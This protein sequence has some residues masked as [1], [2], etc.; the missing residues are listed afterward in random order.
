MPLR[1][2]RCT[3]LLLLDC[4]LRS[5]PTPPRHVVDMNVSSDGKWVAVLL[6]DLSNKRELEIRD[7]NTGMVRWTA[8]GVLC[9]ALGASDQ[10]FL[11]SG[12]QFQ[13]RTLGT[14][15]P[16]SSQPFAVSL[17]PVCAIS[18][19][20][21]LI[22]TS[23]ADPGRPISIIDIADG[24]TI[25]T[26]E[27]FSPQV[28]SLTFSEDSQWLASGEFNRVARVWE[29]ASGIE[30]ENLSGHV[31]WV[32]ATRFSR[33]GR[34]LVTSSYGGFKLWD[35]PGER[36]LQD[37]PAV[38][39]KP[40]PLVFSYADGRVF[41]VPPDHGNQVES[42]P[43]SCPSEQA[44]NVGKSALRILAVG[45]SLYEDPRRNLPV[46]RNDAAELVRVLQQRNATQYRL[47]PAIKIYDRIASRQAI[48]QGLD[49]LA[50]SARVQDVVVIYY[51]GH[52]VEHDGEFFLLP[53]DAADSDSANKISALEFARAVEKIPARR[54]LVIV[55]ACQSGGAL[56]RLSGVL[57]KARGESLRFMASSLSSAIEMRRLNHGIMT[58]ALLQSLGKTA[59]SATELMKSVQQT[60]PET[61]RQNFPGKVQTVTV[62]SRG[63]D[64]PIA[65]R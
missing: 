20:G 22:A 36:L 19:N 62:F 38:E 3:A 6:D 47:E 27:R 61:T 28:F 29:V 12:G 24:K 13:V 30:Q 9:Y 1:F 51:A 25:R 42:R 52:G 43:A 50:S 10:L 64:F 31:T 40:E 54:K 21:R 55:D 59:F 7:R 17:G 5:Q 26:M 60:V 63:Q 53:A 44:M 56:T 37:I 33:G 57:S 45:I 46:A 49:Q 65:S 48:L 4:I 35:L 41:F 8:P 32:S 16:Q 14:G 58:Y 34:C 11:L 23:A 15:E 18:P 2:T 39:A